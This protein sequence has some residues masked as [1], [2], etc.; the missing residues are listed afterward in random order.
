MDKSDE[1]IIKSGLEIYQ[2]ALCIGICSA[3][4]KMDLAF[5]QLGRSKESFSLQE[6]LRKELTNWA[7]YNGL[8][9]IYSKRERDIVNK[10]IG[11][12]NQQDLIN[13]SWKEESLFILLWAIQKF[14]QIPDYDTECDHIRAISNL[15]IMGEIEKTSVNIIPRSH[16][17][18]MNARNIAEGWHWR[19]RTHYLILEKY[20]LHLP[21][22]V[23][24]ESIIEMTAAEHYKLG[25][26]PEPI[27]GDFPVFGKPYK[28]LTPEEYSLVNSITYE[29]HYVLNWIC[30][31]SN[32]W[33]NVPTET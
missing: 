12:L 30:G 24:M 17:E 2:R 7:N 22:G 4:G 5:N 14:G 11:K 29:R 19:A 33:D 32:D 18:I 28:E 26:I 8:D 6:N 23:T 21:A 1:K 16:E 20:D 3:R 31:Y 15:H 25:E 9:K 13:L 10:S 27:K